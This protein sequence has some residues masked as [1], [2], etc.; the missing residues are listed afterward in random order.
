MT[1]GSGGLPNAGM[2]DMTAN[3]VNYN[4]IFEIKY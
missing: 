3:P 2:M 1:Y 4:R